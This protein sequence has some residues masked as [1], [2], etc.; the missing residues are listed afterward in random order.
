[1][2]TND[3]AGRSVEAAAARNGRE[4]A[5]AGG[6]YAGLNSERPAEAGLSLASRRAGWCKMEG[7]KG[8]AAEQSGAV[9]IPRGAV[10]PSAPQ[11]CS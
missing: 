11:G 10:R 6:V 3:D 9:R 1:M 4:S 2:T 5:E 8:V 7:G